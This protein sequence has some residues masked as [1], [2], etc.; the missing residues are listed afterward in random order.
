MP[1]K[2]NPELRARAVRLVAEHQQDYPSQTA[3]AQA[4]A[5]Q[6]GLGR[7]TVRRWLVQTEVDAGGRPGVIENYI[8]D[9]RI[10]WI[11]V[12]DIAAVAA[13][14]LR[15]PTAHAGQTYPLAADLASMHEIA[16]LLSEVTG[17]PWRYEAREPDEFYEKVT[18]AG[19]DAGR[20]LRSTMP[21]GPQNAFAR[22]TWSP[23]SAS[24][25][26]SVPERPPSWFSVKS[27]LAA[28]APSTVTT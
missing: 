27:P 22:T 28:G 10:G 8:A 4:V 2:I 23:V 14:A 12:A 13:A 19:A 6:L 1:K 5:K 20:V 16:A 18:S 15:D 25:T 9:A 11:D 24:G 3:A 21:S 17:A 26:C 7:E